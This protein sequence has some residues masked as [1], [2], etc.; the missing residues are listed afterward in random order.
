[1]SLFV[2]LSQATSST[3]SRYLGKSS[4]ALSSGKIFPSHF[5]SK[6]LCLGM[7]CNSNP[8]SAYINV[9]SQPI[10]GLF[11]PLS[12]IQKGH[13]PYDQRCELSEKHW[14]NSG[15]WYDSKPLAHAA[16]LCL[17]PFLCLL[18]VITLTSYD[19]LLLSPPSLITLWSDRIQFM[20]YSSDWM[21]IWC[22]KI[23]YSNAVK[24]QYKLGAIFRMAGT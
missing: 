22:L 15:A 17:R 24:T 14:S 23:N 7:W 3:Q 2:F 12:V 19:G 1:M 13:S 9:S 4:K 11:C 16:Y 18:L 8:F 20:I 6:V 21:V 10:L 5:V